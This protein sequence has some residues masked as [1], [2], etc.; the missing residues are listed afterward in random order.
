MK[1]SHGS[2]SAT[3][4]PAMRRRSV[5][6]DVASNGRAASRTPSPMFEIALASHRKRKGVGSGTRA[7][8]RP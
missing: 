6:I 4:T 8:G 3:A 2:R 5:V 1:I 7:T